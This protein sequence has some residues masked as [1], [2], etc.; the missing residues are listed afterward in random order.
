MVASPEGFPSGKLISSDIKKLLFKKRYL[1]KRTII[2][3]KKFF[4]LKR[5]IAL[6]K[7]CSFLDLSKIE[8]AF[9]INEAFF[10]H[11]SDIVNDV[12]DK[13]FI[14]ILHI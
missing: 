9:E 3:P 10:K 6:P 5:D 12:K 4:L 13:H 2:H 14:T 8:K 7:I 11:T 1:I